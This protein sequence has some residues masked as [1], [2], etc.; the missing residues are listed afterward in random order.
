[1]A[2]RS[3]LRFSWRRLLPVVVATALVAGCADTMT[4]VSEIGQVPRMTPTSNPTQQGDYRTVSMP[5]PPPQSNKREANSLWRSGARAFFKDQRASR[6]G[7]IVTVNVVVEDAAALQ[8][9]TSTSRSDS[10]SMG[11]P[12]LF[13][14]A[15]QVD[16]IFP[17][18]TEAGSLVSTSGG[19]TFTG[20]GQMDRQETINLTV[21]AVITDVLPNGNLVIYGHQEVRVN[22]ELRQVALSGVVRP[23]DINANNTISSDK[24]AEARVAYGGRGT[25]SYSQTPRW[26]SEVLDIV[27][28]F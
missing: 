4:R 9:D 14:L 3:L 21:A 22:S 25:L 19:R 17:T 24:I 23:Q 13:G 27:M 28:P 8:N 12:G 16:D 6:V 15:Q 11:I 2:T 26:G 20:T 10:N 5:M 18:G 1:M 7:D